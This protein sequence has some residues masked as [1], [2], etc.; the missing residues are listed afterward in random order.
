MCTSFQVFFLQQPYLSNIALFENQFASIF[1]LYRGN[2]SI[3]FQFFLC[4]FACRAGRDI[5]RK[6]Y[7]QY[8]MISFSSKL[9]K[10]A[11]SLFIFQ[12]LCR[13][14]RSSGWL[15][16]IIR[17]QS[18]LFFC[19]IIWIFSRSFQHNLSIYNNLQRYEYVKIFTSSERN[20]RN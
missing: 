5:N 10:L 14:E 9:D 6:I 8:R 4:C 18:T 7:A 15:Q 11:L 17:F 16:F 13:V 3:V 1:S 2:S 20:A 12:D 19:F